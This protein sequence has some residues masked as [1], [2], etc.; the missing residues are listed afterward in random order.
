MLDRS[1]HFL[2]NTVMSSQNCAP[3]LPASA[4]HVRTL[5]QLCYP[6]KLFNFSGLKWFECRYKGTGFEVVLHL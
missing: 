3:P 1:L 6:F 5:L 4:H 2:G